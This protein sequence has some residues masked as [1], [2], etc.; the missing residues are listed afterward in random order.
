MVTQLCITSHAGQ[1]FLSQRHGW[2]IRIPSLYHQGSLNLS[3]RFFSP[4]VSLQYIFN[5]PRISQSLI[6][7]SKGMK[8]SLPRGQ[9]LIKYTSDR[10]LADSPGSTFPMQTWVLRTA[11]LHVYQHLFTEWACLE[12]T[13]AEA[14]RSGH[15][16]PFIFL[17]PGR[18]QLAVVVDF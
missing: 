16:H 17:W 7:E 8:I 9:G 13:S 3:S 10:V 4:L 15:H 11:C 12:F 14:Q 18:R 2:D 6:N 1:D 5:Y